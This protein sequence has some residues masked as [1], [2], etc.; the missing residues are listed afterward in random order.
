M[1]HRY[2]LMLAPLFLSACIEP[3][4]VKPT[5]RLQAHLPADA[6]M[7]ANGTWLASGKVVSVSDGD[8][9]TVLGSNKQQYKIR[10][11]GIDAPEKTQPFGQKCKEDLLTRAV[12]LDGTVEAKKL[13]RYG[14]IVGKVRVN[15]TDIALEQI[16][17][18]CAWY[19][20][21]YAKELSVAD[22]EAYTAA[23]KAARKAKRGLWKDNN[24]QAPWDFRKTQK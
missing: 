5:S 19:Y 18:G 12:N 7:T 13:D 17:A 8:T 6:H 21:D 16:K 23:E 10:L 20:A 2:L 22:R 9:V 11:Q 3:G 4:D 14:R 24:P 1:K 15:G